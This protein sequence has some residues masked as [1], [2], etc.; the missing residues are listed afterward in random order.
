MLCVGTAMNEGI[1][2]SDGGVSLM[3]VTTCS[4]GVT[5]V[6]DD[7]SD[8]IGRIGLVGCSEGSST[9]SFI[10]LEVS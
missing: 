4:D 9:V 10:I 2:S 7:S 6:T 1:G 5:G 8:I 3:I